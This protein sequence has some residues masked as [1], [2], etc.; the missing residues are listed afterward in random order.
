VMSTAAAVV[1][2]G[3]LYPLFLDVIGG[4]K[5]SVG[6]PFFNSV[7]IPLM[8]PM[9]VAMGFGP[10]LSWKRSDLVQAAL[11]LKVA[12]IATGLVTAAVWTYETGGPF[13]AILGI[14][15]ATW[16][17]VSS[18]V[19]LAERIKL[20]RVP[21]GVSLNRLM[22]QTRA[23]W[24]MTLGHLGMAIVIAGI[25]GAGGWKTES[26]QVMKPGEMVTV[27]GYD[28]TFKGVRQAQG[29]NYSATQGTF[30]VSRNGR[31][32]VT[33]IAEKR[34][35]TVRQTPTTEAAIYTLFMG[36]LYAVIGDPDGDD[37]GYVTRLYYNPLV[38]WMW[39]GSLIMM[40]GGVISI[41]DR[42]YRIGAPARP[43][44]KAAVAAKA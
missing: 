16:L 31:D 35:Y 26:I 23:S 1:L 41:T 18:V 44:P 13:V 32:V 34:Q 6:P 24:G 3:T 38:A 12:F 4:G 40:F 33:L 39:V 37:G 19:E 21:P 7:F 42:R 8:A 11:R 15:I 9:L 25:S 36:D 17:F 2:L 22:R 30:Q 28:Y 10:V 29:V 43:A 14:A 20:F 5:V 27:A